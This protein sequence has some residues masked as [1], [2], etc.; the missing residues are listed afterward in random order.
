[1]NFR[2]S[3]LNQLTKGGPVIKIEEVN[4]GDSPKNELENSMTPFN[5]F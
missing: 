4:K 5:Q 1:L 2:K 3:I